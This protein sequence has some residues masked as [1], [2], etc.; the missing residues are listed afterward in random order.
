MGWTTTVLSL[1]LPF[2][3]N[4]TPVKFHE[5]M[6]HGYMGNIAH[7]IFMVVVESLPIIGQLISDF[8]MFWEPKMS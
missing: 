1:N 7:V 6:L 3:L 2:V 5:L 8:G 4:Y